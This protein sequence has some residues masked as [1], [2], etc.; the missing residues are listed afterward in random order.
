MVSRSV[1]TGTRR[2]RITTPDPIFAPSVRRYSVYRGVP[3]NRRAAGLDRTSVLT[4][5]KRTYARLHSRICWAFQRPTSTHFA[6]IGTTEA[7]RKAELLTSINRRQISTA[8]G[9]D[10]THSKPSIMAI[11]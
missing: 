5:Q 9:P 3:M 4:I 6:A 1:Q 10:E 8:L 11:M 7:T 2:E